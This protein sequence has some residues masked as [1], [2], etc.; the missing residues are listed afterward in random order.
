MCKT[1]WSK[2][3]VIGSINRTK[4]Q[5]EFQKAYLGVKGQYGN[6]NMQK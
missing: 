6:A 2:T 3:S 4:S 1:Y 5:K